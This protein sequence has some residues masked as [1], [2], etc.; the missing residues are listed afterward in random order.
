MQ[1]RA[2]L[3][4]GCEAGRDHRHTLHGPSPGGVG[5]SLMTAGDHASAMHSVILTT[6]SMWALVGSDQVNR[7]RPSHGLRC[8]PSD[9][10]DD[11][12]RQAQHS[13]L[14]TSELAG[15]STSSPSS[16]GNQLPRHPEGPVRDWATRATAAGAGWPMSGCAEAG[17][18]T[19]ERASAVRS[20]SN[21]RGSAPSG[22]MPWRGRGTRSRSGEL[23]TQMLYQRVGVDK[24][25]LGVQNARGRIARVALH[26]RDP[27][28][29]S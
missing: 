25:E 26:S 1:V 13:F 12:F 17:T 20:G 4:V 27:V 22:V 15:S 6:L 16:T 19:R 14:R 21:G 7:G 18:A 2:Q 11:R 8:R 10:R 5:W 24:I 28:D 23:A 9:D 3:K 29:V